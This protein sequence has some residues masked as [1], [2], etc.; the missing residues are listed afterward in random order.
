MRGGQPIL[1]AGSRGSLAYA[2]VFGCYFTSDSHLMFLNVRSP[3]ENH[4]MKGGQPILLAGQ[5]AAWHT[6]QF[7]AAILLLVSFKVYTFHL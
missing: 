5:E 7:S 3:A 4:P 1:L 6:Q 2:T